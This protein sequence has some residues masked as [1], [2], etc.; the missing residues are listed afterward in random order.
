MSENIGSVRY[1]GQACQQMETAFNVFEKFLRKVRPSR[2]IEL[3]S[4]KGGWARFLRDAL[5]SNGLRDS[6]VFT[7]DHRFWQ[8]DSHPKKGLFYENKD[9]YQE[10]DSIKKLTQRS[11]ISLILCDGAKKVEEMRKFAPC[12]KSGDVIMAH[13]F[14]KD[15]ETFQSEFYPHRWKWHQVSEDKISDICEQNDLEPFWQDEM[16]EIVWACRRKK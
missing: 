6:P 8:K 2:I 3:G 5:D 14:I 11:G 9:F 15:K 1:H 7:Y 13:D 12:L 16:A 10:F 4:G